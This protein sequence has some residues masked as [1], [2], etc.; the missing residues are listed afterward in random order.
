[1]SVK[2]IVTVPSGRSALALIVAT[3]VPDHHRIGA[4]RLHLRG[5]LLL[6]I[7]WGMYRWP[8]L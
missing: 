4:S 7:A 3:T 6:L 5:C 1:M 2:T 8:N